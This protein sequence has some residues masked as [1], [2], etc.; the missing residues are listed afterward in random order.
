MNFADWMPDALGMF[1][2][3]RSMYYDRAGNPITVGR[4]MDLR[5]DYGYAVLAKTVVGSW[6]VSTVWLGHDHQFLHGPPIIFETMVFEIAESVM[7]NGW[8]PGFVYHEAMF[9]D[10]QA[11]YSTEGQAFAGHEATVREVRQLFLPMVIA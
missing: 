11:R 6:E 3:G 1:A 7:S 4:W 5:A 10:F 8:F 2:D 9:D